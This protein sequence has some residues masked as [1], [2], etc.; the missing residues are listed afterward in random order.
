MHN[1]RYSQIK[2][3]ATAAKATFKI[4]KPFK[5][6]KLDN[7]PA[8]TVTLTPEDAIKIYENLV[9]LRRI[10]NAANT[11]YKEKLIRGFCHLY[12]GQEAVAVGI[13][14]MLRKVDTVVTSYRCH[15]WAQLMS[16]D[17]FGVLAEIAGCKSGRSRGKGGSMHIYAKNFYGGNAIV[18]SQIPL[19]AGIAFAHKYRNDGGVCFAVYGDGAA[20]QGQAFEAY[21]IAKLWNLPC[22]FVCENNIY[23]MGTSIKRSSASTE[24]YKRGDYIPGVW[25]D[26]MDVLASREAAR[27][28]IEHCNSGKGPLIMEMETYR[29]TGHSMSDPGTSY[30]TREEVKQMRENRDPIKVFREKVTSTGLVTAAK[31]KELSNRIREEV[32]DA[33][34]RIK[35]EKESGPEDLAADIYQKNLHPSIRGIIPNAPLAH[36]NFYKQENDFIPLEKKEKKN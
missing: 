18:G 22:V 29:F 15:G 24:F 27:Y 34:E 6:H 20:N 13:R 7:G 8:S 30:R 33:F 23:G 5:L 28:A 25:V 11:M 26:G 36:A 35:V 32:N 16:G 17:M 1:S 3:F 14:S 12:T 21:N 31:L 10:E 2:K 9:M 19:G 4:E